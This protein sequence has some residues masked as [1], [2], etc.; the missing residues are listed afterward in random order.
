MLHT[1][2]RLVTSHA[3]SGGDD[4]VEFLR[5]LA[6]VAKEEYLLTASKEVN[7]GFQI[8]LQLKKQGQ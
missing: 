4:A 7:S 1:V 8:K 6:E 2:Q 5:E 3:P